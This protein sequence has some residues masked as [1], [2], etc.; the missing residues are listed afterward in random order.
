MTGA[1]KIRLR[2]DASARS[3]RGLAVGAVAGGA[4]LHDA[5]TTMAAATVERKRAAR[6]PPL[7][8]RIERLEDAVECGDV[9]LRGRVPFTPRKRLA[10]LARERDLLLLVLVELDGDC[11]LRGFESGRGRFLLETCRPRRGE[12]GQQR[13]H[14]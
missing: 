13:L 8:E 3:A 5:A 6:V 14:F 1:A 9:D 4:W 7:L 12:R 10:V 11:Q 2:S